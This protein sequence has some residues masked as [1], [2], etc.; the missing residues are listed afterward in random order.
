MLAC[1][2]ST[3]RDHLGGGGRRRRAAGLWDP[4]AGERSVKK[5]QIAIIVGLGLPSALPV[6]GR[7]VASC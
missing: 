5:L 2:W 4:K 1:F 6:V 3:A 7:A